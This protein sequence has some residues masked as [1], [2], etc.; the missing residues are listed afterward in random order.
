MKNETINEEAKVSEEKSKSEVTSHQMQE[1]TETCHCEHEKNHRDK[2]HKKCCNK[3]HYELEEAKKLIQELQAT[4]MDLQEK[5]MISKADSINYRK[6]KDEEVANLLKFANQDLIV[7][8]LDM[9]ENLDRASQVKCETEEAMKI[10]K[11]IEMTSIQFKNILNKYGV[12]EI[13]A[14]DYPFDPNYMEAMMVAKDETK[15]D[16]IVLEVLIKGYKL[17]EKVIKHAV[18]KVNKLED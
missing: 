11:G 10:K 15:P 6:R 1:N 12:V 7:D 3:E 4:N 8:L 9:I 2:K 17:K 5:L 16:G 18:V 14:L 13:E